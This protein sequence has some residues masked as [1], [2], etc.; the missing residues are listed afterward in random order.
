MLGKSAG[1]VIAMVL[2]DDLT[3]KL[4]SDKIF[5]DKYMGNHSPAVRYI[6][7]KIL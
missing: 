2:P 5:D 7:N 1:P 4:F 6:C 3:K